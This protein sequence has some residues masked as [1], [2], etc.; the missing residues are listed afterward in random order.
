MEL[1]YENALEEYNLTIADLSDDAKIGIENINSVLKG[2]NMLQKSGKQVSDKTISK[3]KAMDKWVYYEILDQVQGSDENEDE[4]PY[5]ED[6]VLEEAE[7][8]AEEQD[9]EQD[10]EEDEEEDDEEEEENPVTPTT[11]DP[12]GAQ[13]ENDLKV[14]Y[15]NGKKTIT[16]NELKAISKS[17]YDVIFDNYDESGDNG[18]ETSYYTLLETDDELFTLTKK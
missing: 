3:I 5:D 16:L 1:Q 13:I 6:E 11:T 14:A 7:Q 12:K 4:L 10:E 2:V 17:A 8:F 15:D 9:E 18:I